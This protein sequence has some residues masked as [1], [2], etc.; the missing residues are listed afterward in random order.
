MRPAVLFIAEL[1]VR[2]W[3]D[4]RWVFAN[5]SQLLNDLQEVTSIPNRRRS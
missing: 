2:S 4:R 1:R 3:S 5:A